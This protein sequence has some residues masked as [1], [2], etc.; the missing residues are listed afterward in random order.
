M[1]DNEIIE[2]LNKSEIPFVCFNCGAEFE[3]V[4]G[5]R[6][7][8][9]VAVLKFDRGDPGSYD[10]PDEPASFYFS[11]IDC[12]EKDIFDNIKKMFKPLGVYS[13]EQIQLHIDEIVK[14]MM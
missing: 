7:N 9:A 13:G 1:D 8:E 6:R 14:K 10:T 11:C 5:N 4:S 2:A 12:H 3:N